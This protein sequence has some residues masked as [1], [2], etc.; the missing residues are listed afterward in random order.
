MKSLKPFAILVLSAVT[1]IPSAAIDHYVSLN[2]THVAPFSDWSTAATNIQSALDEAAAGETVW[3]TNGI[4][5]A[6]GKSI[7]GASNRVAITKSLLL[8]SINGALVTFIQGDTNTTS[9]VRCAWVTNRATISGF[10]LRGGYTSGNGGGVYCNS[11]NACVTNCV[12]NGNSSGKGGGVYQGSMYACTV[13]GNQ[14]AE[15]GGVYD[16][17]AF[18]STIASNRAN[19]TT[20]GGISCSSSYLVISNC[21]ISDN[22]S[23]YSGGGVNRGVLRNCT[24]ARN[25]SNN[26]G[27]AYMSTLHNCF[28]QNNIAINGGGAYQS[29]LT[30]CAVLRNQ[31]DVGGSCTSSYLQNCTVVG[32]Q[33]A[34]EWTVYGGLAV[35]SIICFNATNS[36]NVM[37]NCCLYPYSG[38][39]S[40]NCI[41]LDPKLLGDSIHLAADSPC[42]GKGAPI[43]VTG[44]DMDGQPWANPPSI[45]C[46]EW[47][48]Q[49]AVV[50]QPRVLPGNLPGEGSIVCEFS[51]IPPYCWW[52][53]NGL[54]IDENDHYASAND[55][56][57]VI[58]NFEV[59]DAGAYQ[60]VASNNFGVITSAVVN[61]TVACVDAS[62]ISPATPFD[63]W[64]AAAQNIQD[65]IDAVG[66]RG[67]VL[68]TNG[69][70][71]SGGRSLEGDITNRMML[72]K[73]VTLM[74]MQ[75]PS[76]TIVEGARDPVTTNGPMS[77]RCAWIGPYG[78]LAGFTFRNGSA[79]GNG[80]G[81]WCAD[82]GLRET[83]VDCVVTNCRASSRGGGVFGGGLRNCQILGNTASSSGGGMIYGF[84]QN[85]RLTGNTAGSGGGAYYCRLNQCTVTSNTAGKG[86]GICLGRSIAC[87]IANN[88]GG[89]AVHGGQISFCDVATNT[90]GGLYSG[91]ANNCRF[92]GNLGYAARQ[93]RV[94]ASFYRAN[95]QFASSVSTN[96]NCTFVENALQPSGGTCT[97]CIIWFRQG[98][99]FESSGYFECFTQPGVLRGNPSRSSLLYPNLMSDGFHL[100]WDS[101]CIG[102]GTNVNL[103]GSD[104]DGDSWTTPPSV[105]CDQWSPRPTFVAQPGIVPSSTPGDA[106]LFAEIAGAPTYCWWTRNATPISETSHY[107]SAH[108]NAVT[109]RGIVPGD[110]GSYQVIASNGFG[111]ITSAVVE[112]AF[113]CVDPASHALNPPYASWDN[114]APDIQTAVDAVAPGGVVLVTNGVYAS[115][116]RYVMNDC[117]NRVVLDKAVTVISV[118]GPDQTVI[119]GAWDPAVT[120][121]AM[122]VRCAWVGNDAVLGGFTLR[123]GSSPGPGG[124]VLSTGSGLKES[125][126]GCIITNCQAGTE[127]GGAYRGRLRECI[128]AGNAAR[129]TGGGAALAFLDR[130]IVQGNLAMNG[131]GLYDGMARN[132][133]ILGNQA[134]ADGGGANG[135]ATLLLGCAIA[136]NQAARAG[137]TYNSYIYNC[138]VVSN[139]A[140]AHTTGGM[141]FSY[142]YNSIIY[143]NSGVPAGN[144]YENVGLCGPFIDVCT[145]PPHNGVTGITN[146]PELLDLW[147]VAASS[148][149]IGS[150]TNLG[151]LGFVDIDGEVWGAVPTIG[152]DSVVPSGLGGPLAISLAAWPE[153]AVGGVLPVTAS[154]S[155]RANALLWDF[156]DGSTASNL[157]FN[158][159]YTWANTGD[160]IVRATAFN[161]D[162]PS[163]VSDSL[164]VK[165]VPVQA[166]LVASMNRWDQFFSLQFPSQPGLHYELQAC[167]N[168]APPISWLTL[169]VLSSAG[170]TLNVTDRTAYPYIDVKFYRVK[171]Q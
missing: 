9:P 77:V 64:A 63:S 32:N 40:Q 107:I 12:V 94:E 24:L 89:Y 31:A 99:G 91:T 50:S 39:G 124:G 18:D 104:M 78:A 133:R 136:Q 169:Q 2:G 96:V 90:G 6:G 115:G 51:G 41:V 73:T 113:A 46:D 112:I 4:Y 148:P 126:V 147:H 43:G 71:A 157:S 152:C 140:S 53:R 128:L 101:P 38:P 149:C 138:T 30:N 160:Y 5:D 13:A 25:R 114:A 27:G 79:N 144:V 132:C 85:C 33:S 58:R 8:R 171:I 162:N 97:N 88:T 84:A 100:A 74:S 131:G 102:A 122:S 45:G 29:S 134:L 146:N 67:A 69:V 127:G 145:T 118:N 168:L 23:P 22:S 20:G 117:T 26:G 56:R 44:A 72:D 66:D 164:P 93:S 61:I 42:I 70:Y 57:L 103:A 11:T 52:M 98:T 139:S 82:L 86:S 161:N 80:A 14:A 35:N 121:G 110:A 166:P 47:V 154:I 111:M 1:V 60:V 159:S 108:S 130:C 15:G 83:M 155:G 151:K 59:G 76:N 81:V 170:G 153:V 19:L 158:A 34:N 167:T 123:N 75:G 142:P 10:T 95:T 7:G 109:L 125:V 105:G 55:E 16:T 165:V 119:E 68:V 21:L 150:G 37:T 92:L 48:P 65:A 49:L 36:V 87:S 156:G 163:G 135:W 62:N 129:S 120:N 54:P 137:G 3:V 28:V 17:W 106:L 143:F 141:E 116:G